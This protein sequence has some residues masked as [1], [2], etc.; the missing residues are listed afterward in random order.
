MVHVLAPFREK[1]KK[2]KKIYSDANCSLCHRKGT[3]KIVNISKKKKDLT[4]L[5]WVVLISLCTASKP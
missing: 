4:K 1:K 2:G 3:N 5:L